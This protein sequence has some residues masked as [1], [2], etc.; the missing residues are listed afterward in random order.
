MSVEISNR[1][2][3]TDDV[4]WEAIISCDGEEETFYL[5]LAPYSTMEEVTEAFINEANNTYALDFF[6]QILLLKSS[7][8]EFS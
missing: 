1:L 4:S 5:D 3:D 6:P 7:L 2:P 8:G